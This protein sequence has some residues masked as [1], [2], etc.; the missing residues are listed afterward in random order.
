ML[1]LRRELE[2][3]DRAVGAAADDH[4]HLRWT[5]G[6]IDRDLAKDEQL[7][8]V[9]IR[10]PRPDDLVDS[11][12]RLGA[13]RERRDRGRPAHRPDLFDPEELGRGRHDRCTRRGRRDLDSVDAG[14]L[15][16]HDAHH[17]RRD[18]PPRHVH[19]DGF[20]RHP[21]PFELDARLDLEAQVPR[22]LQ[23]M[24]PSNA[25]GEREERVRRQLVARRDGT[26][27]LDAVESERP[28]A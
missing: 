8:L 3:G 27:R 15:G 2:L 19:A 6:Q 25:V 21:A 4:E 13:V 14:N 26:A 1:R 18:E 28:L 5:R 20:E 11:R 17:E 23:R 24:P 10:V 9:H 7:R 12:D 22:P 16:R